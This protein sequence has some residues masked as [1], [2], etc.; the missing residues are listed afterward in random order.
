MAED[1]IQ[2]SFQAVLWTT[3]NPF[4][5]IVELRM[6]NIPT[7]IFATVWGKKKAEQVMADFV[8]NGC[9]LL[10]KY[11]KTNEMI[12]HVR[13]KRREEAMAKVQVGDTV[14]LLVDIGSIKKGRVCRVVEV[15]EPSFYVARGA[16]EWED[17]KY[18][19]RVL[20]VPMATDP[21]ALGPKDGVPLMRG[22]FGPMDEEIPDEA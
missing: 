2:T 20:P 12:N 18:P 8:N 22:E 13:A 6:E 15:F 4:K 19:I 3:T 9:D 21:V 1:G 11:G 17:E 5:F 7:G 16:N 14:R 10:A